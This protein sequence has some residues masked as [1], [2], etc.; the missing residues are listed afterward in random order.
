MILFARKY[1]A[2]NGN[3]NHFNKFDTGSA[4]MSM[5]LQARTMGL[6]AHGMGGYVPERC[7][8]VTG[9]NPDEYDVCA[10]VAIG[11]RDD[12]KKLDEAF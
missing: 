1:Y 6:D 5:L 7:Y 3:L 2:R 11:Y 12:K 8:E 9:L 10:M 4:F